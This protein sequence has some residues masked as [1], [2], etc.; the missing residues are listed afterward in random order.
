[1]FYRVHQFIHAL[2]PHLD[3]SEITWALEHLPPQA[4]SLFLMQS[5][6]EQRHAVDVAQSL[7]KE[8]NSLTLSSFQNLIAAALLHDCGKSKV[9]NYLWHRVF[10]VLMQ[11]APPSIS[12]RLERSHTV[13]AT[14]LMTASQHAI[15]GC[16]LA[17]K[18]GLNTVICRMIHE[19]HHPK[20]DLG[21][22]L[23]SADN[24]H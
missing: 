20:T 23:E 15:W 5:L 4:R 8:K 21:R 3:S 24:A 22:I 13:F 14:P 9:H 16:D 12:S 11:K 18:A 1:M 7:M 10:I 6:S 17:Q 2:Y 19:H